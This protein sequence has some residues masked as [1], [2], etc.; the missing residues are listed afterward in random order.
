MAIQLRDK[1]S[2]TTLAELTDDELKVLIDAFE[3]ED[4]D[5][6]DYWI[7]ASTPEYLESQ[8]VGAARLAGI[9]RT[10]LQGREGFDVVWTRE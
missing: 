7:D 4:S 9:L 6:R 1:E 3:E 2:G 8:F 5:D 10:A